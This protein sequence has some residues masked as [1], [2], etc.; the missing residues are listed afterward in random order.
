MVVLGS[1]DHDG[2]GSLHGGRKTRILHGFAGVIDGKVQLRYV[3]EFCRDGLALFE[4][5]E[6]ELC[7]MQAHTA[8]ACR[9]QN[10]GYGEWT[11]FI[12]VVQ[13]LNALMNLGTG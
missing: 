6:N 8:F 2:I 12:H 11:S 13:R 7:G 5:T 4:L 9:S 10:H 3:D 1:N